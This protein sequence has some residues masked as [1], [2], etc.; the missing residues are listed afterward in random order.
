M[1]SHLGRVQ[2]KIQAGV[3]S[4]F[5][6][7]LTI[8][9]SVYSALT[10]VRLPNFL[11]CQ[12]WE[13]FSGTPCSS[14]LIGWVRYKVMEQDL[15]R[16]RLGFLSENGENGGSDLK[17]SIASST[18]LFHRCLSSVAKVLFTKTRYKFIAFTFWFY[19]G[20]LVRF[21]LWWNRK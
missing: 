8:L 9:Q 20:L 4:S 7:I 15:A 10:E 2:F 6:W 1:S 3:L 14:I 11:G 18:Y 19:V 21:F 13:T 17:D 16:K 12:E 5:P